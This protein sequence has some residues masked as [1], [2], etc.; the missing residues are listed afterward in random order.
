M[1]IAGHDSWCLH[2]MSGGSVGAFKPQ[3]WIRRANLMAATLS[4][5]YDARRYR[6]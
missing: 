5:E 6:A 1:L 2:A 4:L 3:A